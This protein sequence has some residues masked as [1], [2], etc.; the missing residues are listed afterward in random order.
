MENA[1]IQ[2]KDLLTLMFIGWYFHVGSLAQA[3]PAQRTKRLNRGHA[4]S[5]FIGEFGSAGG[6]TQPDS[7]P[8]SV[9]GPHR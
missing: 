8:G 1:K 3:V 2:T 6:P 7:F 4:A 9:H 5:K